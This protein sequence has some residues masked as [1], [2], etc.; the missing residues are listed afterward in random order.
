M[1]R[2]IRSHKR[3]SFLP[4]DPTSGGRWS[5]T[6]KGMQ[7]KQKYRLAPKHWVPVA[8]H[9]WPNLQKIGWNAGAD[10]IELNLGC[11]NM[12]IMQ[13]TMGHW[14]ERSPGMGAVVGLSRFGREIVTA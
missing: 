3:S 9:S 10:M 4:D 5:W 11:P 7:R 12:G 2:I 6:D 14:R 1:P 13:K 8:T